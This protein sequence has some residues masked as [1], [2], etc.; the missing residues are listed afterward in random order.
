MG[1]RVKTAAAA[2]L[3]FGG[4][5]MTAIIGGL[6]S[7][8]APAFYG[9]LSRPPWAPPS[10]LFG[11]VWTALYVLMAVAAFLVWR[12]EGFRT[13]LTLYLAQLVVNGLWSWLFFGW[14]LGSASIT[15]IIVL[16]GM[17]AGLIMM[18]Y[19]VRPL[20]AAMLVP[21]LAWVTF[22]AVLNVS[23]VARNP[24]LFT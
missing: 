3:L 18:F 23:I 12:R 15:D 20:A 21:Y 4:T 16:W 11:P 22:A 5:L 13:A 6:A 8:N 9:Q 24:A 7:A 2:V 10:W 17:I 14:R 19:R 1:A